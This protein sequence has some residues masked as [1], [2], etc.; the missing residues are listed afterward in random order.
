MMTTCQRELQQ[1]ISEIP[2][3]TDI[4]GGSPLRQTARV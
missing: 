1:Y 2:E 4:R 3:R